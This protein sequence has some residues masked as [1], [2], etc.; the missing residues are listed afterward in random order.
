LPTALLEQLYA[1]ARLQSFDLL[2]HRSD[3]DMQLNSSRRQTAQ[4]CG[5]LEYFEIVQR[6]ECHFISV[7]TAHQTAVFFT[8]THYAFG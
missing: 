2:A 6:G 7:T 5:A 4:A 3:G 1:E 8:G